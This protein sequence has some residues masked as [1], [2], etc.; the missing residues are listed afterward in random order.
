[1]NFHFILLWLCA[2]F[3]NICIPFVDKKTASKIRFIKKKEEAFE[4]FHEEYLEEGYFGTNPYSYNHE[5]DFA[6]ML[7]EEEE[8]LAKNLRHIARHK[9]KQNELAQSPK[10]E[11]EP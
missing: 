11:K 6:Q 3:W 7:A 4:L 10:P 5:V 2:A 9:E 8:W 1:M